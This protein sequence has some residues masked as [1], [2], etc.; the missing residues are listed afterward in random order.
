[1]KN[2]EEMFARAMFGGFH[3]VFQNVQMPKKK[4]PESFGHAA[5][6]SFAWI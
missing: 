5:L 4:P 3:S 6:L 1:L 2:H